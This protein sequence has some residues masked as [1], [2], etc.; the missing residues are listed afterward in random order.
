MLLAILLLCYNFTNTLRPAKWSICS[1]SPPSSAWPWPLVTVPTFLPVIVPETSAELVEEH[2]V[3]V[4]AAKARLASSNPEVKIGYVLCIPRESFRTIT[5]MLSIIVLQVVGSVQSLAGIM[6][7]LVA[8]RV[9]VA[10]SPR[11]LLDNETCSCPNAT[12]NTLIHIYPSIL[13]AIS[14]RPKFVKSPPKRLEFSNLI[15][16][17]WKWWQTLMIVKVAC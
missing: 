7:Y 15:W 5:L 12:T 3:M 1:W 13:C 4:S 17:A 16:Q 14:M 8:G 2:L 6:L 10:Q 11:P 9:S